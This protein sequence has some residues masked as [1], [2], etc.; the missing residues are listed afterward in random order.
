M[1]TG[2]NTIGRLESGRDQKAVADQPDSGSVAALLSKQDAI[3]DLINAEEILAF[4]SDALS[5]GGANEAMVVT[6][7]LATD[8]I[9]S[10]QHVS[11]GTLTVAVSGW[12][13]QADDALDGEFV[14]DPGAG[15]LV[16]VVVKRARVSA[17][18]KIILTL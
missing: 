9:L 1:G 5:G 17:E 3:L 15:A 14:I 12:H 7:L 13:T 6:G 8:T 16:Q 18:A 2:S 11:G 4:T 10:V